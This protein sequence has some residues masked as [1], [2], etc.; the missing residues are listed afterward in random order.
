MHIVARTQGAIFVDHH[1]GHHKQAD[2][3]HALGCA[4]DPCQHQM[5]DVVGHVV[6]TVSDVNL[7]A[8]HLV[9]AIGLRLG[10]GAHHGQI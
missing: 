8:K 1:F 10:A 5:D 4:G 6:F 7:G 9:S 2:A 3:F